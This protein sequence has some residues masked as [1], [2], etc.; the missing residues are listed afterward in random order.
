MLKVNE[1]GEYIS[2]YFENI[3][4]TITQGIGNMGSVDT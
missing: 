3:N 1:G 2:R 4:L